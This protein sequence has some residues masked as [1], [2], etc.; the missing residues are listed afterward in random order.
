MSD[1]TVAA[2]L[3]KSRDLVGVSVEE[4]YIRKYVDSVYTSHILGYTGN[5][6]SSELEELQAQ[7]EQYESNDTV[8]KSGIEQALE[9]ELQG[10]KGSKKVYVDSVGRITEVVTMSILL[11]I[12]SFRKMFTMQLKM[13]WLRFFCLR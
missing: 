2:I 9:L 5:V 1:A 6:S 10:T 3:E 13:N 12:H 11:L 4:E 8:G 7:N